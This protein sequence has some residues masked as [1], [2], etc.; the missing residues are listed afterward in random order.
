MF[1]KV[2]MKKSII[3]I[4]LILSACGG[5]GNDGNVAAPDN[6]QQS[7][8][9]KNIPFIYSGTPVQ[10][11]EMTI[12]LQTN[13]SVGEVDW[14]ID[15]QP[16]TANLLLT[17]D[18]E[19]KSITFMPS[20]PGSYQ[21]SVISGSNGT[22]KSTS[23]VISPIFAFDE[24]KIQGN[25]GSTNID[26]ITGAIANQSWVNSFSL[27][28][29]ELEIIVSEFENLT[30]IGYD[31]TLGLLVEYDE[32]NI[33]N[34][35]A[36]E[37]IATRKGVD[38]VRN[39]YYRGK[40]S[41]QLSLTP[42][43]GSQWNDEGDNWHLEDIGIPT[44]WE[45]TRGN[46]SIVI[47]VSEAAYDSGHD[48]LSGR[49]NSVVSGTRPD[50]ETQEDFD[51]S[52]SHGNA[53][54]GSIG[55]VTDNNVGVSGI[56]WLSQMSLGDW[57]IPGLKNLLAQ[58][59]L[60]LINSSWGPFIE[61]DFDP[62][63]TKMSNALR[64]ETIEWAQDFRTLTYKH[65]DVLFVWAAG[66]GIA[67]GIG[68]SDKVFGVDAVFGMG[69]VQYNANEILEKKDNI[70]IV[71]AMGSDHRL[72][73]YSNYGVSVDI[74]APT[75]YKSLARNNGF[76]DADNYG[77][78]GGYTGTSAAAPV[79]TGVASLIYSLYP[80]FTASDVKSILIGTST[81]KV[82]ERHER[83]TDGVFNQHIEKLSH[84]IPILNAAKALEK[85]Q[86][87]IDGKVTVTDTIPD[88]FTPQARVSFKS[89]DEKFEVIGISWELQSSTD[90]G[91]TWN[92]INGMSV[93]GNIAEPMLDINTPYQ[94]IVSTITLRD[95]DNNETKAIKEH[96]FSYTTV[97]IKANDTVS[98]SSLSNVEIGLELISGL[99][100]LTTDFTDSNGVIA[101]YVKVGGTYKIHGDINGY[102]KAFTTIFTFNKYHVEATLN[103]TSDVTGAVGSL[104]GQVVDSN[105]NPIIGVSVRISGGEQTNG[106]FASAITGV[107]GNYVI[108]NISKI[109]SNKAPITSFILEASASGFSTNLKNEVIVLEGK[110]RFENFILTPQ[111]LTENVIF[112]SDFEQDI[113]SWSSTGFWNKFDLGNNALFNS[114]VE[115]GYT[116]IAPDESGLQAFLPE[117]YSGDFAW[118]YGQ[119]NTGSFIGT[120]SSSDSLLSGGRSTSSNTGQL[121]SPSISLASVSSPF[122]RFRTWW[123]IESVN[124]NESG[125]DIMDVLISTDNGATYTTL[126]KLNPFIDPNDSNR[127]SKPFSSGGF[128]RKPVWVLE[129]INLS[130][131]MG[132][133]I[134]IKFEFS[135]KDSIYN[136]FRGWIIDDMEVID[137]PN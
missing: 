103:M 83:L 47:G 135:T 118:W 29:A 23:F 101:A 12:S 53:T 84:P 116:S 136:G 24:S 40:H 36:L 27:T 65:L 10:N 33:L 62:T 16:N 113:T 17:K 115:G 128:N 111:D 137:L 102:K 67:N 68:N 2:K 98:L 20:E 31:E 19:N 52:K 39:R 70:I 89:I 133:D 11:Q 63:N 97:D 86:E 61:E 130:D 91:V 124:P 75:A 3:L 121:I 132:E 45:Y 99:P 50:F 123:E 5:A 9:L 71:A 14:V 105:G 69:S 100:I 117:A 1:K 58:D 109:D 79:V 77:L 59:S 131:Y 87:I 76:W 127:E 49:F 72:A 41:I 44:A 114:L 134:V 92:T 81:E 38:S 55:A 82:T 80:G 96:E 48:E 94:R 104:G 32:T 21:I 43:D 122:L 54:A 25:D 108:S 125:F 120:Q 126:K 22:K 107:D 73:K 15:S 13:E 42:D 64:A 78:G 18:L 90:D 88:P 119:E 74:A 66:N 35:E 112:T 8:E 28:Q 57:L 110:E 37:E 93:D 34:K 60:A 106:F 56:N 6:T 129:E 46:E 4:S 95:S 7:F 85:A 30:I 51:G 26:S